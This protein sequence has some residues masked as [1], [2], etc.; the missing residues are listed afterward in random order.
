MPVYTNTS[1]A[2]A[3]FRGHGNVA[4]GDSVV[5]NDYAYPI[6]SGFTLSSYNNKLGAKEAPWATTHNAVLGAGVTLTG[7]EAYTRVV[8]HNS[9]GADISMVANED[10]DVLTMALGAVYEMSQPADR[11]TLSKLVITGSGSSA[12]NITCWQD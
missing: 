3:Y 6:P 5:M 2:T 12:I 4:A 9:S 10:T 7:L 11:R 8:I 1:G